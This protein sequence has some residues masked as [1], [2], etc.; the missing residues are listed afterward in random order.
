MSIAGKIGSGF[1]TMVARGT[2]LATV[3]MVAYDAHV[4]GKLDGDT[5]SLSNESKR[6]MNAAND[7]MYL[8]TPSTTMGKIKDRIFDFQMNNSILMPFEAAAGYFGGVLKSCFNDI[9]PLGMGILALVGNKVVAKTSALG[10]ILYGGYKFLTDG[11]G[12]GRQNRL[13]NPYR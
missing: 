3:G 8:T 4:I 2:G 13:N 10:L 1:G 5:Y 11:F 6:L 12:V 9:I 7:R